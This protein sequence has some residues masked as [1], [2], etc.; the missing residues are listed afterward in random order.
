[1]DSRRFCD[2]QAVQMYESIQEKISKKEEINSAGALLV[3]PSTDAVEDSISPLYILFWIIVE[4]PK[5]RW[6][7]ET[8]PDVFVSCVQAAPVIAE[9]DKSLI[10]NA[11]RD[12]ANKLEITG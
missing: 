1:M 12:Y 2:E 9:G 3:T 8:K 4:R 10:I 7:K 6:G 5:K 11:L